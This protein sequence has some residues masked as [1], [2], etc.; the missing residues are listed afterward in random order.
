MWMDCYGIQ[1]L[2]VIMAISGLMIALV[3]RYTLDGN[4]SS[5]IDIKKEHELKTDGIYSYSRHPIYTGISFLVFG[6]FLVYQSLGT[7]VVFTI[8][9]LFFCY[10]IRREE[11]LLI[12]YFPKAYTAYK[13]RTKAL[14]PFIV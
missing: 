8:V 11:A 3:A 12:E 5:N 7:L 1:V 14:I 10:K 4:W 2:G 9:I 6:T 13:K